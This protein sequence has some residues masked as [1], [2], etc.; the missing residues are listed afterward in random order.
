M[1]KNNLAAWRHNHPSHKPRRKGKSKINDHC[2]SLCRELFW[3]SYDILSVA[4][5]STTVLFPLTASC[6]LGVYIY[7][8]LLCIESQWNAH[9]LTTVL[10][11]R[12]PLHNCWWQMLAS[13]VWSRNATSPHLNWRSRWK[14]IILVACTAFTFSYPMSW[15]RVWF[16]HWKLC[17]G[18][19][20]GATTSNPYRCI[21]TGQPKPSLSK[22]SPHHCLSQEKVIFSVQGTAQL[23]FFFI[24]CSQAPISPGW[25]WDF[26]M[27]I[28]SIV[29]FLV[30][31][32]F[33][34]W[35]H[36]CPLVY[37]NGT[38]CCIL[39]LP[40]NAPGCGETIWIA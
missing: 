40:K 10:Y 6:F 36:L 21:S 14:H 31:S 32:S 4:L 1:K 17:Q 27:C 22:L 11:R 30:L 9:L 29:V 25:M 39:A 37:L 33:F 28:T 2:W 26:N 12:A 7:F 38:S 8:N 15:A 23:W 16:S 18:S 20:G 5:L 34:W 19:L 3:I 24:I 13:S 35:P